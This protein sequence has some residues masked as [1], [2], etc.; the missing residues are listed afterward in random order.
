[1]VEMLFIGS[2]FLI[3]FSY[4]GYPLTLLLVGWVRGKDVK[5]AE[6]YPSVTFIV[7]VHNEEARIKDK[8]ENTLG[9]DYPRAKLEI[10]VASDG[11]SDRTN[12]IVRT[13]RDHG[14]RLLDVR[15]RRGKENAQKEAVKSAMGDVIVFS[16]VATKMETGGLRQL[17]SSFADPT[18]GCVSSED[19][20]ITKNGK[21]SGE[22][23]YVRYE[24]WLRT[25]ESRAHSLVGLSGSLFAAR[26]EVCDDFSGEMQSDFR[27]VLNSVKMGLRGV[28]D[29][30]AFGLYQDT[31]DP[32]RE[33]DRKIRTVVRGLTVFFRHMELLNAFRYGW[34]SY[35]LF[36]H[37]LLRWLVPFF[38]IVAFIS[39]IALICGPTVYRFLMLLQISFYGS[40]ILSLLRPN[41]QN[42]T[43]IRVPVYFLAVNTSILLAW[44]RY[45]S[46]QRIITWTPTVR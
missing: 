29:P 25:L 42:L 37:K 24:M 10:L 21:P 18:V 38:L 7:T 16:D 3:F 46:G 2:V 40:G 27:T 8:L 15:D 32:K 9:L 41:M 19:R 35:Q 34:F 12:E 6:F 33:W 39:N 14:V 28:S 26:K 4:F 5:R 17:V 22:G 36:C 1:M 45:L 43:I 20:L 31:A 11:S 23:F 13:H 30:L 44:W